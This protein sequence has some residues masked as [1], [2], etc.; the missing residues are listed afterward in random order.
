MKFPGKRK[1]KHY[2]PV[3]ADNRF[4]RESIAFGHVNTYV[5]GIDQNI[6]DITAHVDDSVLADF[7]L[8]KGASQLLPDNETANRL[9]EFL[10]ENNL[11]E[12][13]FAGGTI[14]N[15]LHNYSVLADDRSVQFGVMSENIVIGTSSYRYLCNTSSKVDLTYLQPVT[16]AIGRGF[17]LVTPDG[18]R[19]FGISPG[20]MNELKPD[21]ISEK[22]VAGS[23]ALVLCAY[24]LADESQPIYHATIKAAEVALENNVPVVLT[25]GSYVLVENIRERLQAFIDRYVTIVAMNE[26]E[27]EA[28]TG[29][30]DRVL[31][32][33]KVLDS[34]D[35]VLLTAGPEGLYL[36]GYCDR[37]ALRQTS[38]PIRSSSVTDFNRY[39]FSRPMSRRDCSDPVKVYAHID[40]YMGGPERIS[41][42]NGAG[43]GA[44]A[45]V[46]HDMTA[47]AFHR[48]V[49]P[50]S[51]KH[52]HAYLTYSSFAQVCKYANRV[53][54]QVL[55]Q[56]SPRLS[57]GLPEREDSLEEA[58]WSR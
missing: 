30:T 4:D 23:S 33:E 1:I 26:D 49:L 54:Y 39:E 44:L 10:L 12:E 51:G 2:F 43:D 35:L 41:N 48:L 52:N 29:M 13:E 28:L 40:P 32:C 17:A 6:V 3:N 18:D 34:V 16:G 15:T 11:I 47:N 58:Y 27:A 22:M 20:L 7:G 25:L 24:T 50:T 9:Y 57:R 19:T 5:T 55:A 31:A 14:G 36:S 56:S 38:N 37:D 53:S 42:T 8:R 46:V 45:A 21:Y